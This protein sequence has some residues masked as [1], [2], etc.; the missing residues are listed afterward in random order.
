M[1]R[2]FNKGRHDYKHRWFVQTGPSLRYVS[3][4][5]T[6]NTYVDAK[7]NQTYDG[8]LPSYKKAIVGA[9]AGI[10][11]VLIDP[12]GVRIT[13]EVR[14]TRWLGATF[15]APPTRSRRDQVEFLITIGF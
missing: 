1:L 4:I 2:R 5:R 8:V 9:T 3:R 14:Y 7:G 15:D 10:G 13:P 11:G 12:V 6:K